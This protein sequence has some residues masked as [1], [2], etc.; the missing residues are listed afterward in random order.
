MENVKLH[1]IMY[2]IWTKH[3]TRGLMCTIMLH[4]AQWNL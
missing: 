3:I 1:M 2:S 4:W